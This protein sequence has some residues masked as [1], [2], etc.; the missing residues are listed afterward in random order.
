MKP[1]EQNCNRASSCVRNRSKTARHGHCVGGG[2]R[3]LCEVGEHMDA[4]RESQIPGIGRLEVNDGKSLI[5]DHSQRTQSLAE[6]HACRA[7]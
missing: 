1:H 2:K 3:V 7:A 5:L 4:H 6:D